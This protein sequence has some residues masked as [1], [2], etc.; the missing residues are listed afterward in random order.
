LR[1]LLRRDD[2]YR[3]RTKP[4]IDWE[5]PAA[6]SALIDTIARDAS[7]LLAAL[8]GETLDAPFAEAAALL[9][10]LLGQDLE[11]GDEDGPFR[12]ARRVA[13]DR[14]ISTV[15]AD[16]RHGHKTSARAF[17]GY[18]GHVALDP[19]SE[20][21]TATTVT[22]GNGSD[23]AA[24]RELLA[25]ELE[26]TEGPLTVYGDAAYGEGALLETL[27]AAGAE[28][29]IK[30]R[31]PSAPRGRF[32][33]DAFRVDPEA[34]TVT[35]PAGR[36]AA[37][38]PRRRGSEARFGQACGACPLMDRCTTDRRRGRSI[39][40]GHHEAALVRARAA[41]H[42]RAWLA[43]YRATRPLVE[44]RIAHLMRRRHGGRRARVRGR[45]KVAADLS[46]LAAATNLMRLAVL[47]LVGSGPGWAM[48]PT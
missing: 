6:R 24:A 45:P 41:R 9:A 19:D 21:I 22:A 40:V 31:P 25:A 37:L 17:D 4:A 23:A 32:A 15:D 10:T 35:C 30:V 5:D 33:K 18:K 7:A 3:T 26:P 16:A 2:D 42:D 38:R 36:T 27:E 13:P 11:G 34:A 39:T 46:L 20:L 29:R 14:V 12:I 44:R 43:D 28:L 8:E 47:G 48:R 1:A